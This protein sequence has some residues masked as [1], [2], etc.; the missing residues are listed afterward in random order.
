MTLSDGWCCYDCVTESDQCAAAAR[1]CIQLLLPGTQRCSTETLRLQLELWNFR[2]L[3][4]YIKAHLV[5]SL[6]TPWAFSEDLSIIGSFPTV[7]WWASSELEEESGRT[8]Y[9][10]SVILCKQTSTMEIYPKTLKGILSFCKTLN[11][12]ISHFAWFMGFLTALR[13]EG[14]RK[15]LKFNFTND[16]VQTRNKTETNPTKLEVKICS[17]LVNLY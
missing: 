10:F 17:D 14:S 11:K 1:R 5:L 15:H 2:Y 7:Q 13:A 3:L 4:I 16:K 8:K 6:R 9:H 12:Y